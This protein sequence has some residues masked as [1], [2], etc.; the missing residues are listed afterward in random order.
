MAHFPATSPNVVRRSWT[1]SGGTN[2]SL[3]EFCP[4]FGAAAFCTAKTED[5]RAPLDVN[6]YDN[7]DELFIPIVVEVLQS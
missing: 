2:G 7:I 3:A 5:C 6:L 1:V 4:F